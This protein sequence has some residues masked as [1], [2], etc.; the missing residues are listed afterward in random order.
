MFSR[1]LAAILL[2]IL[3]LIFFILIIA[4]IIDDGFPAI[5][6]QKRVGANNS[7]F[8][9]FKFRTMKNNTPSNK[10]T[11]LLENPNTHNT[12][13]GRYFRKYSLDEL[14]QLFNILRGEMVFIGP[15]PPLQN[16]FDLIELR[17][18]YELQALKPGITGWAQINGRDEISIKEKVRLEHYYHVNKSL[19][20]N[21]KIIFL[22][23]FRVI[24]KKGV[25]H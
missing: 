11:H 10:A 2:I 20:L 5:F 6:S 15:R 3:S 18:Q 12:F 24:G 7:I 8:T 22:T 17:N 1:I 14:P 25:S 9:I 19:L 16:Q 21:F 13:L 23:F 4:I